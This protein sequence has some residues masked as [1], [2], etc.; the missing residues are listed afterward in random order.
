MINSHYNR[1]LTL[2]KER[3]PALAGIASELQRF[4]IIHAFLECGADVLFI[5]LDGNGTA[6]L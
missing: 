2:F 1:E 3:L 5:Y 6:G 4:G